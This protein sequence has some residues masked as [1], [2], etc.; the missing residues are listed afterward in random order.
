LRCTDNGTTSKLLDDAVRYLGPALD[1]DDRPDAEVAADLARLLQDLLTSGTISDPDIIDRVSDNVRELLHLDP[2]RDHWVRN[3]VAAS[4][5]AWSKLVVQLSEAHQHLAEVSWYRAAAVIDD[6]VDLYRTTNSSRIYCRA[7]DG[8]AVHAIVTPTLEAGFAEQA[9]LLRHLEDHVRHL[10]D[11]VRHLEDLKREGQATPQQLEDLP[12]AI[13]LRDAAVE[14]FRDPKGG[15]DL[16]GVADGPGAIRESPAEPTETSDAISRIGA[17]VRRRRA[18]QLN[19]TSLVVDE[20]LERAR[21]GFANSLDYH[22]DVAE[23]TDL[24]T[25]LLVTFLWDRNQ[26]G[27]READYLYREDAAEEDLASDLHTFLRGSG[28]L[29]SVTTEVRHIAGG[30]IDIQFGFPG[31]NLYVELKKDATKVPVP[32]KRSY[33]GQAASYQVA[34]KRIGFLLVLKLLPEKKELAPHLLDCLEVV[35][36]LDA[37]GKPR[38]VAAVTLSGAR[39]KP[40][41]M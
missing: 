26:L 15:I 23:A 6:I 20:L 19:S 5:V 25:H 10:E 3:R 24:I 13:D 18:G 16:K 28:Q 1:N 12:V 2:G 38:H 34:D 17:A 41:D 31:F 14:Q 8:A 36:V 37:G 27:E 11:H 35:E 9:S 33:L 39:T 4:H 40:S 32:D 29:G 21:A 7:E 30:R 22:E